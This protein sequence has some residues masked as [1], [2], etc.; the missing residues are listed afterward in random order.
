M[1]PVNGTNRVLRV[2]H[3]LLRSD[4]SH[5]RIASRSSVRLLE[6]ERACERATL[7]KAGLAPLRTFSGRQ[8]MKHLL[9]WLTQV[10]APV[11]QE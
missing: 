4:Q 9:S 2:F 6:K 3:A 5:A 7:Q 8:V 11:T 10:V 1:Y